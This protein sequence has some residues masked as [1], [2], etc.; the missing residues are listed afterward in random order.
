LLLLLLHLLL[1]ELPA[2]QLLL[3]LLLLHLLL[4]EL[5]LA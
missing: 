1:L 2:A 4:L 5:P 3:L